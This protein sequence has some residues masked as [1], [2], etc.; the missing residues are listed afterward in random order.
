MSREKNPFDNPVRV[1]R[2]RNRLVIRYY[3]S[4]LITDPNDRVQLPRSWRADAP[5]RRER[6]HHEH[7]RRRRDRHDEGSPEQA[8]GPY[9]RPPRRLA[10]H[11][12]AHVR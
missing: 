12:A 10:H 3:P 9:R 11:Q 6:V 5:R 7:P 2:Q 8:K 1:A 4:G